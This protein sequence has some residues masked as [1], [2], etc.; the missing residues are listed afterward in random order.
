VHFQLSF[1]IKPSTFPPAA[2]YRSHTI[3]G[4]F[5]AISKSDNYIELNICICDLSA[6]CQWSI[7]SQWFSETP[8]C[9]SFAP[10]TLHRFTKQP[11][12]LNVLAF[13]LHS[14]HPGPW[15][16][17]GSL[18][19][20]FDI[21]YSFLPKIE[22]IFCLNSPVVFV[23]AVLS[24]AS[25]WWETQWVVDLDVLCSSCIICHYPQPWTEIS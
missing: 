4:N 25:A 10:F 19:L 9:F 22:R 16:S 5:R 7:K 3:A 1:L 23:F 21:W 6:V 18:I 11:E 17:W 8:S 12:E 2:R 24:G 20:I 14:N 15:T 13:I